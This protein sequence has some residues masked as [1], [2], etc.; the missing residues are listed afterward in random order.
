MI[1]MHENWRQPVLSRIENAQH[2]SALV[3]KGLLP[4][5]CAVFGWVRG[6]LD[7]LG[8][9]CVWWIASCLC[10]LGGLLA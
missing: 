7:C 9:V 1:T 3:V 6:L 8:C 10:G 5:L 4:S 2:P